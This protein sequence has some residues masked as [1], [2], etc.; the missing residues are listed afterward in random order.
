M[1]KRIRKAIVVNPE[2]SAQF[3][4]KVGDKLATGIA[5]GVGSLVGIVGGAAW[6][7]CTGVGKVAGKVWDNVHNEDV[8]EEVV[9]APATQDAVEL[10]QS[11]IDA[12]VARAVEQGIKAAL[13]QQAAAP[14]KIIRP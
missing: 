2:T 10:T 13:A 1:A 8:V 6:G 9:V 7:L 12:M 3:G 11:E 14:S 5:N 4:A